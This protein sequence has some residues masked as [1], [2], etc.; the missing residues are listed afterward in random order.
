MEALTLLPIIAYAAA[1][2][3]Y[4]AAQLG[5]GG[6]AARLGRTALL[7]AFLA[8]LVDIGARCFRLEHP[9]SSTAEATAFVGW[10]LSGGF[11]L[12]TLRYRV[13][14]AGGFVLSAALVLL[15]LGRVLPAEGATV[16][17]A[18]PLGTTHIFLATLG[19]AIF[20]LAAAL[21]VLY[22]LQE[23]R[24]KGGKLDLR[25]LHDKRPPL[26]T[27]DRLSARC[28]SAGFP[29]LTLTIVTGAIW[30]ARLGFLQHGTAVRPEYLLSLMSWLAF[31]VLLVARAGAGWQGRRAAWLTL[32]GFAASVL[33][34]AGYVLRQVF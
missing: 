1:T 23:R 32:G 8:E 18:S 24:L 2:T 30:V 22:L 21:A 9:L 20:A 31:G 10:L 34:L 12:G 25:Q 17:A 28:V 11:W 19:L 14:A 16:V 3:L 7:V 29:V 26:E 13:Q 6:G 27:L 33:V 4:L 5:G 15:V